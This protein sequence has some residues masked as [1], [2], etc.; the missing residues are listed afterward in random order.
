M[1][2]RL[3]ALQ[4]GERSGTND[5]ILSVLVGQ[6]EHPKDVRL[7]TPTSI[8]H[9]QSEGCILVGQAYS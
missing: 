5:A 8:L 7:F 3:W 9:N 6:L 1:S 4:V 2:M